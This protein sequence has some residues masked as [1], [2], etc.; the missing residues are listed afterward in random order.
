MNG[1][2]EESNRSNYLVVLVPTDESKKALKKWE[3]LWNRIQD[4]IRSITY[5]F[6]S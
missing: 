5:N 2:T 6:D 4:F 1:Y 3:K